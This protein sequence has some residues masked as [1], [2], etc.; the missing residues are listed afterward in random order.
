MRTQHSFL[1]QHLALAIALALGCAE[2]SMAQSVAGEARPVETTAQMQA[3]LKTFMDPSADTKRE[4]VTNAR[5]TPLLKDN[6]ND[7]VIVSK[8]GKLFGLTDGGGGT[9]VLLLD[10]AGEAH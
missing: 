10:T 7:L 4:N 5:E 2:V 6:S 3:R 9:N 8:Q 1:P